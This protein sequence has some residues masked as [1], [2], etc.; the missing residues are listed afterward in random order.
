M[1]FFMDVGFVDVVLHGCSV[2]M[3]GLVLCSPSGNWELGFGMLWR[4]TTSDS[5][6][7]YEYWAFNRMSI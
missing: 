6:R 1:L 4:F 3:L 5:V 7:L 2:W